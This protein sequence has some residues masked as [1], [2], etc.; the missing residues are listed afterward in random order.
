MDAE[1]RCRHDRPGTCWRW[2]TRGLQGLDA[3]RDRSVRRPPPRQVARVYEGIRV[4]ACRRRRPEDVVDAL[5]S[6]WAKRD[7]VRTSICRPTAS[8]STSGVHVTRWRR[9]CNGASRWAVRPLMDGNRCW[10]RRKA[11][12]SCGARGATTDR[13]TRSPLSLAPH[14]G[15]VRANSV[16]KAREDLCPPPAR[17]PGLLD[18]NEVLRAAPKPRSASEMRGSGHGWASATAL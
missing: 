13:P 3:V 11:C 4:R 14:L 12:T 9:R 1:R 17:V 2:P 15:L 8:T 10:Q 18:E 6:G 5:A 7:H 16:S